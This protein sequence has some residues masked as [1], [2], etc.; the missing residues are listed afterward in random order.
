M[1][2]IRS[3]GSTGGRAA[4]QGFV[5]AARLPPCPSS[6]GG[7]PGLLFPGGLGGGAARA[8]K[9][10]FLCVLSGAVQKRR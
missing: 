3:P 1:I 2:I 6:R 8:R 9:H 4:P 5:P 7:M 10:S